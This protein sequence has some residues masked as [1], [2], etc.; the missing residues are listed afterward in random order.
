MIRKRTTTQRG[1]G[2]AHRQQVA[3]L[4]TRHQDGT[5]CWWCDR[6]MYRT[7]QRNWDRA[8]LEGDHST[9]RSQGGRVADRLLHSTCNRSRGDG[10]NDDQRPS[11]TGVHPKKASTADRPDLGVLAMAWPR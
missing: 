7:A 3:A 5:L 2:W 9:P 4:F 6:P 1:L 10:S 11:M 8:T